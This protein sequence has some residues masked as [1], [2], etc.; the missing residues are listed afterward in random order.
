M[1]HS[2][3]RALIVIDVQNEY[4][5]G[6]LKI[7]YPAVQTSLRNI[8][9]AIDFANE[10][11]IPVVV[12]QN[13]AP[14]GSP[15]LA[16]GSPGWQLHAIVADRPRD[17][18]IEKKL[19]SAFSGTDLADWIKGNSIDT[20]TVVGY[21][22]H[23][24]VDSTIKHAMHVGLKVEFLPDAAGS[25]P[26]ENSAGYSSAEQIHNAFSI[27]LQ[28]R[29]AAVVNTAEWIEFARNGKLPERDTIFRSSQRGTTKAA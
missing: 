5:S 4:V 28:S 14:A 26:Y 21:M 29:F 23:N 27:V 20:L 7:E 12:V 15:I 6:N 18:Y 16:V 10:S 25:L 2:P 1:T 17:H 3:R 9:K 22:T 24:C 13:S 8:G 11:A 19:P